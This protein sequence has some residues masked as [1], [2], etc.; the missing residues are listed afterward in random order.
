MALPSCRVGPALLPF[1]G[2]HLSQQAHLPALGIEF[3]QALPP[4]S[5]PQRVFYPT[6]NFPCCPERI[7]PA[8]VMTALRTQVP[9]CLQGSHLGVADDQHITLAQD[10]D[11]RFVGRDVQGVIST[12]AG[13][14]L[15]AQRQAQWVEGGQHGLELRQVWSV[16]AAR[17]H[18]AATRSAD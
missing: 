6:G 4:L 15:A 9:A 7:Q 3:F 18:V 12:V 14:G 1:V 8:Q 17:G 11:R 5:P 2:V 16:V 10:G 13:Q